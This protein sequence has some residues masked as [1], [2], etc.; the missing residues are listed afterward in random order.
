M[1]LSEND[2]RESVAEKKHQIPTIALRE[3]AGTNTL[4]NQNCVEKNNVLLLP[5]V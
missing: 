5:G 2:Q 1:L 3:Y 4:G